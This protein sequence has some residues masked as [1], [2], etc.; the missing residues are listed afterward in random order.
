MAMLIAVMLTRVMSSQESNAIVREVNHTNDT[1]PVTIVPSSLLLVTRSYY[2][3][4]SPV[5]TY[6][7][8]RSSVVAYTASAYPDALGHTW[9]VACTSPAP[10]C[11]YL[12][13]SHTHGNCQKVGACGSKPI[14]R[15]QLRVSRENRVVSLVASSLCFLL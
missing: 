12:S 7:E 4:C 9:F 11:R 5:V 13:C 6:L 14:V 3:S 10:C 15:P 1:E 2:C 8:R